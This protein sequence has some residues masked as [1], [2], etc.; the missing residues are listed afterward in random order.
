MITTPTSGLLPSVD[1]LVEDIQALF[2]K[3]HT[4]NPE[5]VENFGRGLAQTVKDRL[6]AL[7]RENGYLRMSNLGRGDRQ[8]WYEINGDN[9]QKEQFNAST[10]IKFLYG[11]ILEALLLFLAKEAGHE[12]TQEQAEVNLNGIKGHIDAIIDG[13]VVDCKSAS[14]YAFQKFANGTLRD[15]DAFGYY[16]QIAAYSKS[17]GNRDGAFLAIDKTLGHLALLKV[18]AE[19][20]EPLQ[21]EARVEHL[22]EV[23]AP[24]SPLPERCYP[25]VPEGESG[26]KVLGVN[27]SYCAHKF[28]CW[29]D[30]N[31]GM[32]L[33]TFLYAKGPRHFTTIEREPKVLE[34]TF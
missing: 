13:V 8:L 31:G 17:L 14:T 3:P 33:R 24:G 22:K 1:T 4:T 6:E 19:E 28:N 25:D 10:L 11:D 12:V 20:L 26:N 29:S 9:A 32:G 34:V 7:P 2:T 16:E 23:V 5:F 27:C 21:I 30:A 18:P 15:D